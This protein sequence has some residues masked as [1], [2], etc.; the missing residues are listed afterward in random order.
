[1]EQVLVR[2]HRQRRRIILVE[3]A[4]PDE[5]PPR[6]SSFIPLASISRATDTSAFS[7]SELRFRRYAP[8]DVLQKLGVCPKP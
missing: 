6:F 3:R 8:S 1:M 4:R 5:V 2:R 7:R